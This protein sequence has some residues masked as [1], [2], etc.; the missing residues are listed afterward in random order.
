[1]LKRRFFFSLL[2]KLWTQLCKSYV[3]LHRVQTFATWF[4]SDANTLQWRFSRLS[5][6]TKY[7]PAGDFHPALCPWLLS[8]DHFEP[9]TFLGG[10]HEQSPHNFYPKKSQ[11]LHDPME[12]LKLLLGAHFETHVFKISIFMSISCYFS[13]DIPNYS[14]NIITYFPGYHFTFI[15][16]PLTFEDMMTSSCKWPSSTNCK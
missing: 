3:R 7:P 5:Y 9:S 4:W 11:S 14:L 13:T 12:H 16:L 10:H 15:L 1:M 2:K 8:K 6:C